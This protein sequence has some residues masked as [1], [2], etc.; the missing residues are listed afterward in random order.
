MQ[1]NEF[2]E[3]KTKDDSS[4]SN[5]PRV[6]FAC[7][8]DDFNEF[9]T[10]ICDS[11]FETHDCAIY[12]TPDMTTKIDN[13]LE[14]IDFK[15]INLFVI[16]ITAK[17]LNTPSRAISCDF[18]CAKKEGIPVLPLMMDSGIDEVYSR[19]EFFGELQYLTP[20]SNNPTE[21]PY[22]E[23]LKNYLESVLIS[24]DVAEQ[25]RSVFCRYVFLS[26]RKTDREYA[27]TLLQDIHSNIECRHIPIWFDEF[28][29]PGESF[30][31]NIERI[32]SNAKLFALL[33]TPS[34]FEKVTETN[35]EEHDNYVISTE[36]PLA[37][38]QKKD[39]VTIEMVDTSRELLKNS[40]LP[41]P[42]TNR[43]PEF[44]SQLADTLSRIA[45]IPTD[46]PKHKFLLGLAYLHG[47]N[48]EINREYAISLITAAAESDFL[49]AIKQ[50]VFLYR[51]TKGSQ[52]N[53]EECLKWQK[54]LVSLYSEISKRT[55]S[56]ED[57]IEYFN[58]MLDLSSFFHECGNLDEAYSTSLCCISL[59]KE[60]HS[61][62]KTDPFATLL[63]CSYIMHSHILCELGNDN[64]AQKILAI[65]FDI[66]NPTSKELSDTLL[67]QLT[68]AHLAFGKIEI[69][70]LRITTADSH[71][72]NALVFLNR[73]E[74]KTSP[75]YRK[76]LFSTLYALSHIKLQLNKLDA[77]QKHILE[78]TEVANNLYR[79][80][81][82]PASY[83]DLF[84][85]YVQLAKIYIKTNDSKSA[86]INFANAL[87]IIEELNSDYIPAH[88]NSNL[89]EFWGIYADFL[90]S[91]GNPKKARS[92]FMQQARLASAC[93]SKNNNIQFLLYQ[94]SAI[95][96]CA[97]V[98]EKENNPKEA[99]NCYTEALKH[100][101]QAEMQF[102]R[103]E[104]YVIELFIQLHVREFAPKN[105]KAKKLIKDS[106]RGFL[107][108]SF[109]VIRLIFSLIIDRTFFSSLGQL[110]KKGIASSRTAIIPLLTTDFLSD[111][112][113][114]F[115]NETKHSKKILSPLQK[116]SSHIYALRIPFFPFLSVSTYLVSHHWIV[117]Y[118]N[119]VCRIACNR[120]FLPY[121]IISA[122][123][124]GILFWLTSKIKQIKWLRVVLNIV[125][126]IIT[127]FLSWIFVGNSFVI[128]DSLHVN[129]LLFPIENSVS[130]CLFTPLVKRLLTRITEN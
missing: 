118:D 65:C 92:F 25:I 54:K 24:N 36:L 43:S 15:R 26:Y 95:C 98:Y 101:H 50:L 82:T 112:L 127:C 75:Q 5:K 103:K 77:A 35:G 23:K 81:G 19:P 33:V 73:F 20:N 17:L 130:L 66:W 57:K 11:I 117:G 59:A 46:S 99:I 2:I 39:I 6:Y 49:P 48:F 28:L 94:I 106:S 74:D 97:A 93:F 84:C 78:A 18:Q 128:F 102:S 107:S 60:M 90:F 30:R 41:P 40:E 108:I 109:N 4:P 70:H 64:A 86:S 79:K 61:N 129:F 37:K 67:T 32:V 47:I 72:S 55:A 121:F 38:R 114:F 27:N 120:I 9:F 29:I 53:T 116:L 12:Y 3:I 52:F 68:S 87:S 34:L 119:P 88:H 56:S 1:Y 71:L 31:E 110:F 126:S 14:S 51:N 104:T 10:R 16:P 63:V 123:F 42:I 80:Y 45:A 21:I 44:L 111:F 76:L 22:E 89:C 113:T 58:A 62:N 96:G 8:P 91:S 69:R 124:L 100:M 125:L 122:T 115:L 13:F 83:M 85:C 7:H 105:K